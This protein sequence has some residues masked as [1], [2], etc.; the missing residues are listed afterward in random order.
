MGHVAVAD[1]CTANG[2]VTHVLEEKMLDDITAFHVS[3][4]PK[5][6]AVVEMEFFS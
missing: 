3:T 1:T 4:L 2:C 5:R 6:H